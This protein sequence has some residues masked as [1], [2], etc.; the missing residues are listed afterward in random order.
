[1]ID[2]WDGTASVIVTPVNDRGSAAWQK[3]LPIGVS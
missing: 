1:M 2:E 3:S